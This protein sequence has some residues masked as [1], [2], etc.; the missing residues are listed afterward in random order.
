M[1]KKKR[2]GVDPRQAEK[3]TKAREAAALKKFYRIL[4]MVLSALMVLGVMTYFIFF[5]TGQL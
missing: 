3:E 4:A 5:I 2:K 1:A